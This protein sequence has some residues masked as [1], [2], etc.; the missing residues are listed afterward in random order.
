MTT[1]RP[2]DGARGPVNLS[3][4][5][6][7][8]LLIFEIA[9]GGPAGNVGASQRGPVERLFRATMPKSGYVSNH[10]SRIERFL[11]SHH[12]GELSWDHVGAVAGREYERYL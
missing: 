6:K 8:L 7:P 9:Y 2:S 1:R 12:V 4:G 10:L 11:P 3:S 5:G